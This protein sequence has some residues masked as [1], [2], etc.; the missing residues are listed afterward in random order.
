[1]L[2]GVTDGVGVREKETVGDG[3]PVGDTLG[4]M[5]AL[6][7][8]VPEKETDDVD[9]G[10]GLPVRVAVRVCAAAC[11]ASCSSN[12]VC[13]LC[14]PR[15]CEDEQRGGGDAFNVMP[16]VAEQCAEGAARE[17]HWREKLLLRRKSAVLPAR[18]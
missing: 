11:H 2:L 6:G 13:S 1:M 18:W 15:R 12:S 9:D 3:V 5:D 10:V 14:I 16:P 7:L 8:L 4:V 17:Q